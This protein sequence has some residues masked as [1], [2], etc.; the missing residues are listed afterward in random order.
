MQIIPVID[1]FSGNVV[2]AYAGQRESYENIVTPLCSGSDPI[3]IVEAINALYR[4][5]TFYIADLNAIKDEGNNNQIISSLLEQYPQIC[6]WLDAGSYSYPYP[7]SQSQL[8]QITASE[9]N[10]NRVQLY[11]HENRANP[12]LSLDFFSDGYK[13]DKE[14]LE[15]PDCWPEDIIVMSLNRVG[16]NKGPD[17][18]QFEKI[19]ALS[20]NKRFYI[21]GGVRNE[22]D[23]DRAKK[24]GASGIL[25]ASALHN[26]KI[27]KELLL[28]YSSTSV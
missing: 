7:T 3:E 6:F 14:I 18:L 12:I 27:T 24:I 21:S 19:K 1:L 9:T 23:L 2:R 28:K 26:G 8:R 5:S 16:L 4:F 11:T 22:D 10:I 15:N 17:F 20:P 25:L 13:G